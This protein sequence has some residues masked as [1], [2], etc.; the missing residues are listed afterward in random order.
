VVR[1]ARSLLAA[2]LL[3][4]LAGCGSAQPGPGSG[5]RSP[6]A[7]GAGFPA[8]VTGKFGTTTVPARP[9]RV[10]AMSWMDADFA[11]SL[12]V[13]PVGMGRT[14]DAGTGIQPWT[15]PALGD[16]KP[17]LFTVL[18]SDP[19][20]QVAALR[21]DLILATKDYNLSGSYSS[22]SQIAPVVTYVQ[23]ANSDPWQQDFANVAAALGQADQGKALTTG[24]ENRI[25]Q[26]RASHPELAGKTF[27]YV[28]SPNASGVYTVNSNQDVSARFLSQLGLVLNPRLLGLPTSG[29]P[30]RS[31]I[32]TENLGLLD[33]DLVLA[34]GTPAEVTAFATNPVVSRLPS[35]RRGGLV[36]WDY[37]TASALGFPSTLSLPWALDHLLPKLV[38][39]A[40]A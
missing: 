26:A 15:A 18:G 25:S 30:G 39:A 27:S 13:K 23:A 35:I 8:S 9:L 14:P 12:G 38:T 24:I 7:P 40:K 33:A 19:V 5:H 10:V 2:V 28:I 31:Q 17:V 4:V 29:L 36:S 21:P 6:G 11:L 22:L 16:S 37:T 34:V 3:L 20:E 1:S 32:G